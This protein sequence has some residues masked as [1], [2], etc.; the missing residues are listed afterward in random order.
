MIEIGNNARSTA[1]NRFE[2]KIIS[3]QYE[4]FLKQKINS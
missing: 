2:I 1:L 4:T 3:N